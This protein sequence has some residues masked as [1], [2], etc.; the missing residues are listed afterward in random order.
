M[1][2]DIFTYCDFASMYGGKICIMGATETL[3]VNQFPA[4]IP[5]GLV[6][7]KIRP[8]PGDEG[9]RSIRTELVDQDG[10]LIISGGSRQMKVPEFKSQPDKIEIRTHLHLDRFGNFQIQK[11]G[12]YMLRLLVDGVQISSSPIYFVP[13]P[14]KPKPI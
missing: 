3:F 9:D 5:S 11:L 1:K 8:E 10:K 14:Q 7:V 2:V 4:R 13:I 6:A 12:E